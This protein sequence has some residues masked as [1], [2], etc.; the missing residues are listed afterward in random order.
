MIIEN[1]RV[2]H[3]MS[4]PASPNK[5][6]EIVVGPSP[7]P[8]VKNRNLSTEDRFFSRREMVQNANGNKRI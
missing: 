4:S 1:K 8:N 3:E 2:V 7:K 6:F 5:S